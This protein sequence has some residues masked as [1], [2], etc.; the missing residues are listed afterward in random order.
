MFISW[1]PHSH[2][3]FSLAWTA[4]YAKAE[5]VAGTDIPP[6]YHHLRM[7]WTA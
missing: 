7:M 4:W 1:N 6:K 3:Y 5:V 2:F